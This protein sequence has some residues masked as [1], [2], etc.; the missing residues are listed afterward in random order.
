MLMIAIV[1]VTILF[2]QFISRVID[3]RI[4]KLHKHDA[5][6]YKVYALIA[7]L[8]V[9]FIGLDT[10]LHLLGIHLNTILAA[11]GFLAVGAGFASRI[12]IENVISGLI[13]RVERIIQPGDIIVID[14]N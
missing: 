1:I 3:R 12:F 9:W 4:Q 2:G 14:G 10:V 8:L 11:S 6:T 13:L 7:K 5:D